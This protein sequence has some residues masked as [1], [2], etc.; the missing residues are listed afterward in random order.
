MILLEFLNADGTVQ[1]AHIV[2]ATELNKMQMR[3]EPHLQ[4]QITDL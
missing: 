1:S 3:Y 4:L 2:S